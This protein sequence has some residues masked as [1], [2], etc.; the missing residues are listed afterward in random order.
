MSDIEELEKYYFDLTGNDFSFLEK[1]NIPKTEFTTLAVCYDNCYY[2]DEEAIKWFIKDYRKVENRW[3]SL[4]PHLKEFYKFY[5]AVIFNN[6][7]YKHFF[8]LCAKIYLD[9]YRMQ[10]EL[11]NYGNELYTPQLQGTTFVDLISG[12]NFYNF[13]DRLNNNNLYYLIDKSMMTCA[14]LEMGK[15]RKNIDNINIINCDIKD[16]NRNQIEGNVSVVR[17]NNVWRY[18]EDFYT[19]IEKYKSMIMQGGTFLF[20]EYSAYKLFFQQNNPYQLYNIQSYFN[21]WEQQY[22]INMNDHT[23]FDSLIYKKV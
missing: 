8:E 5:T 2:N 17:V 23:I 7:E 19:C 4:Y 3:D 18:V 14:C 21:A 13:Y 11:R 15:K 6:I 12:F 9:E 10:P 22:I 20:Q 1:H 16:V